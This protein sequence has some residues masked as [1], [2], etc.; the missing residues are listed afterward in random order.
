MFSFYSPYF[1]ASLAII[2]AFI[3]V[4]NRTRWAVSPNPPRSSSPPRQPLPS[5]SPERERELLALVCPEIRAV[6]EDE[7]RA[8]NW[9]D[10]GGRGGDWPWPDSTIITL[11]FIFQSEPKPLAPSLH[12]Q[13]YDYKVAIGDTIDCVEHRILVIAAMPTLE[14]HLAPDVLVEHKRKERLQLSD[15]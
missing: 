10:G 4:L 15:G 14:Q 8:G 3:L 6:L 13:R 7:L 9:I 11:A 12:F 5:V 2:A 1:G